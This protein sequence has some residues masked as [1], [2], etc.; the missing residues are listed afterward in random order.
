MRRSRCQLRLN[1]PPSLTLTTNPGALARA[2][3]NLLVNATIHAFEGREDRRVTI[4]VD[5]DTQRVRILVA[6]NGS[7]MSEEAAMRAFEPF[8]TTRRASGGSGLGLFS[9]RRTIEQMLDGRITLRTRLGH[10]TEFEID[11]PRQHALPT[12]TTKAGDPQ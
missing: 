2:I 12:T 10:G 6:D 5:A 1:C 3:S 11:L 8:F 4:D 7:G 9:C